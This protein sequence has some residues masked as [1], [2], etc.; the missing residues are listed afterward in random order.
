MTFNGGRVSGDSPFV[1]K[2]TAIIFAGPGRRFMHPR[3]VTLFGEPIEC[4]DTT[5][6]LELTLYTRITWSPHIDKIRKSTAQ[7][8]GMLEPPE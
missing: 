4:V 7:R 1:S 2:S 3:P 8:M 6:Y 5:R